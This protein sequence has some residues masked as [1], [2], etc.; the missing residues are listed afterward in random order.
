MSSLSRKDITTLEE[1]IDYLPE[2]AKLEKGW[3]GY[4]GDI[5]S[6]VAISAAQTY[7][8][9]VMPKDLPLPWSAPAADGT[10]NLD[11]EW[12]STH[13]NFMVWLAFHENGAVS[14]YLEDPELGEIEVN[15][16][17]KVVYGKGLVGQTVNVF[18]LVKPYYDKVREIAKE[19]K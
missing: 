3:D 4:G 8:R 17:G 10:V 13:K 18:E 15:S 2:Y 11:W 19:K 6:P 9:E 14:C 16:K 1:L 12:P 7:L 5:I